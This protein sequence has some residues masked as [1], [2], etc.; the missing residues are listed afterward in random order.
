MFKVG[1]ETVDNYLGYH[2][3]VPAISD[4]SQHKLPYVAIDFEEIRVAWISI[5]DKSIHF[6]QHTPSGVKQD[7][8]ILQTWV[9]KNHTKA[10]KVWNRLNPKYSVTR[11]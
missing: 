7:I 1:G 5:E 10:V 9:D 6:Y 11:R 3:Y 4:R 2:Y 8:G